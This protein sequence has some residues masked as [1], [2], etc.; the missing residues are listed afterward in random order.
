MFNHRCP[1]AIISAANGN[2]YTGG[3]ANRP[4]PSNI[5]RQREPGDYF[6]RDHTRIKVVIDG[7]QNDGKFIPPQI[8]RRY[9]NYGAARI[10]DLLPPQVS[11][12]AWWPNVSLMV[13]KPSRSRNST[14][15]IWLLLM[16]APL[17]ALT[18]AEM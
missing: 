14:A 15:I 13:L 16:V 9:R 3:E 4:M 17:P 10:S 11:D 8:G 18:G 6:L 2:S 12:P 5:E 1:L 7:R